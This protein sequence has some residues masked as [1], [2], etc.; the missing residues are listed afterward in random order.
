MKIYFVRISRK[1]GSVRNVAMDEKTYLEFR[2]MCANAGDKY[3]DFKYYQGH[4]H[5]Y[6]LVNSEAGLKR[7][8]GSYKKEKR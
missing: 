5:G 8:M 2:S 6:N 3:P 4:S 1:R 7:L